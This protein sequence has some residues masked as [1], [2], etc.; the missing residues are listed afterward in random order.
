MQ[1]PLHT[2]WARNLHQRKGTTDQWKATLFP[3]QHTSCHIYKK[4]KKKLQWARKH[5]HVVSPYW[6]LR[7]A[8]QS[9]GTNISTPSLGCR[10]RVKSAAAPALNMLGLNW[11]RS[12][13]PSLSASKQHYVNGVLSDSNRQTAVD[14]APSLRAKGTDSEMWPLWLGFFFWIIFHSPSTYLPVTIFLDSLWGQG[15]ATAD[16]DRWKTRRR[17]GFPGTRWK[18]VCVCVL[19]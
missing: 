19:P 14:G 13:L 5:D 12:K 4:K 7:A 8:G 6:Q 17:Q 1:L 16:E 3:P 10:V 15:Q 11:L 2:L 9:Y 18:K